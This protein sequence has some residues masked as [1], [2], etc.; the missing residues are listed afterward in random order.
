MNEQEVEDIDQPSN[1]DENITI[2]REK[3]ARG[4]MSHFLQRTSSRLGIFG[5][6]MP[7]LK[8]QLITSVRYRT[9]RQIIVVYRSNRCGR[10]TYDWL[11]MKLP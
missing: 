6:M 5:D 11:G 4:P 7:I 2:L 3:A 8:L 1:E 9:W 10:C